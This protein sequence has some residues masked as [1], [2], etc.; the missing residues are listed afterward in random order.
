MENAS[1]LYMVD[2]RGTEIYS[3]PRKNVCKHACKM[4]DAMYALYEL[5]DAKYMHACMHP[6]MKPSGSDLVKEYMITLNL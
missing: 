3:P 1:T 2:A 6:E 4:H 5:H